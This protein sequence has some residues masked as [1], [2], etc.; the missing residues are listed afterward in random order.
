VFAAALLCIAAGAR[1]YLQTAMITG[2]SDHFGSTLSVILT[3]TDWGGAWLLQVAVGLVAL[4]G[5]CVAMRARQIGWGLAT[6]AAPLLAVSSTLQGHAA[7]SHQW[8]VLA[9]TVDA[10]HILGAAGWLGSLLSLV[11]IGLPAGSMI[12]A[13]R[14]KR[15]QALVEAFSPT[16]LAFAG[17]VVVTGVGSAWLR[18]GGLTPLWTSPYGKVLLVKLCVL[19]GAAG[20]GF[21]NWQRVRPALGTESAT[22]RL[23]RSASSELA[24]GFLVLIVTGVLV[25]M[26]TPLD[27]PRG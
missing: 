10:L 18:L 8:R 4:V 26:P 27:V 2:P 25:A 21:Y 14:W 22:L 19:L 3:Q 7:A 24:I 5:F 6:L 1:L 11:V 12:A 13:S 9:V 15:V 16:A 17:L 23:C 20:T